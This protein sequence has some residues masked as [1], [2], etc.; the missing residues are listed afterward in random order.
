MRGLG[1]ENHFGKNAALSGGGERPHVIVFNWALLE[2]AGWCLWELVCL[3]P[4][5]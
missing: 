1:R 5:I 2:A 3:L 4:W